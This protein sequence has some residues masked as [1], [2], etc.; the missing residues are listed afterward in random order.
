[1]ILTCIN[2]SVYNVLCNR[3]IGLCPCVY[4]DYDLKT[5]VMFFL[6]LVMYLFVE[7][8]WTERAYLL[9]PRHSK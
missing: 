4:V 2:S 1:L 7:T 8:I 3:I 9:C 6:W 5:I